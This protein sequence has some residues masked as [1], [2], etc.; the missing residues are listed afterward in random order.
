MTETIEGDAVEIGQELD[1]RPEAAVTLFGTDDPAEVIQKATRMA[2]ALMNVVRSKQLAKRIGPKD[3]LLVEAWTC[4]G[5]LV[6]VFPRTVWTRDLEN[7]FEARVEAVTRDGSVVGAA[8]AICTRDEKNW[9][10]RDDY[11]L[12]SMAQTRAMGKALR[13]PLGFIAVLAGFEATP[14]EEMPND[15][16]PPKAQKPKAKAETDDGPD[17]GDTLIPAGEYKDLTVREV[18]RLNPGYI[19][20]LS[21]RKQGSALQAEAK[22]FLASVPDPD[23]DPS[24][25]I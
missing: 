3:Y 23:D 21:K 18:Y 20:A 17:P 2:D 7:G 8:E 15:P 12:K 10:G 19:T 25:P 5:S 11:A 9:R 14:A 24:L 4:L 13:M 22:A 1:R 6:G 16:D